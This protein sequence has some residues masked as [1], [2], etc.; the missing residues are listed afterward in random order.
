MTKKQLIKR[1]KEVEEIIKTPYQSQDVII[2]YEERLE[3]LKKLYL[4]LYS[5]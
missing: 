5:W 2:D 3:F 4:A 1:I